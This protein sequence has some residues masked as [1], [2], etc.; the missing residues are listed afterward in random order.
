MHADEHGSCGARA[1]VRSVGGEGCWNATLLCFVA[2]FGAACSDGYPT[3]DVPMVSP[4][5]MTQAELLDKMNWL[6]DQ[7]RLDRRWQYELSQSCR[8]T[9]TITT[10]QIFG[11]QQTVVASLE[12]ADVK[13]RFD[14]ADEKFDVH[15]HPV[16]DPPALEASVLEGSGWAD[17]VQMKSL[18]E[19]L[20]RLC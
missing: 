16:G 13:M 6:G 17:A 2:F 19:H 3:K 4:S 5:E 18:L 15:V 10:G 8:L 14:D 7:P 20:Q 12:R 11:S 1:Q 9:V